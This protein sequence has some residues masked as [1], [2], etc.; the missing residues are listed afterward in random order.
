MNNVMLNESTRP[1]Q[2]EGYMLEELDGELL[3]YHLDKTSTIYLNSSA[4][5]VWNLCDGGSTVAEIIAFLQG[6]YPEDAARIEHDV[7][8]ALTNLLKA[9]AISPAE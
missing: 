8:E 9:G 7:L 4:A 2:E 1:R 5:L 6:E 3:L